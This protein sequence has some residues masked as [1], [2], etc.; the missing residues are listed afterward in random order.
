MVKKSM[1][2]TPIDQPQICGFGIVT[3]AIHSYSEPTAPRYDD[4]Q[5]ERVLQLANFL[6]QITADIDSL[7]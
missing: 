3:T 6:P 2:D 4:I 1:Q 7:P 5:L